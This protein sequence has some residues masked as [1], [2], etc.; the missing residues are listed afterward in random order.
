M[1]AEACRVCY[2]GKGNG[3]KTQGL[4]ERPECLFQENSFHGNSCVVYISF[5]VV[6]TPR[7]DAK[8]ARTTPPLTRQLRSID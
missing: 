8:Y 5:L 2:Q 6:D 4:V 1:G 3:V 7:S